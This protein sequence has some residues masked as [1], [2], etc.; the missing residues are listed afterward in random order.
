[1]SLV[2]DSLDYQHRNTPIL[3]DIDLRIEPGEIVATIGPSGVGKTT[4]FRV[5]ALF[6]KPTAGRV[7]FDDIDPWTGNER[8]RLMIRRRISMVFQ[9]ASRFDAS[10]GRNVT[11]GMRVRQPG[12]TDFD[13]LWIPSSVERISHSL[14]PTRSNWWTW[15]INPID[16]SV[17]YQEGKRNV[18]RLHVPS[19]W[20]QTCYSSTNRRQISILEIPLRSGHRRNHRH[21]RYASSETCC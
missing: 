3:S 16:R 19:Q 12:L 11:Y 15:R 5:I 21:T 18:S 7:L 4:L 2:I 10:I 9:Q 6:D 17:N 1:M 8:R 13:R 14:Q 20:I